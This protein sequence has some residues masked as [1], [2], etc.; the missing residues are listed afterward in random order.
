VGVNVGATAV[1]AD[2]AGRC[3]DGAPAGGEI[4]S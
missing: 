3:E 2:E 4:E 1:V